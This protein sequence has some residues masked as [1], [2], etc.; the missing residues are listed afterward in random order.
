MAYLVDGE[1]GKE[2]TDR[3]LSWLSS[4]LEQ[5]NAAYQAGRCSLRVKMENQVKVGALDYIGGEAKAS[6]VNLLRP[7]VNQMSTW[8]WHPLLPDSDEIFELLDRK[9]PA[10]ILVLCQ[11]AMVDLPSGDSSLTQA[12]SFKKLLRAIS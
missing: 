1:E 3:L 4:A 2:L 10:A 11:I 5:L 7:V 6:G 8:R 12:S 9:I